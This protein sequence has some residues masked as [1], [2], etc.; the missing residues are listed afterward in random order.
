MRNT[1]GD[2]VS[3]LWLPPLGSLRPGCRLALDARDG[4]ERISFRIFLPAPILG[5][6]DS[7]LFAFSLMSE[8]I[9]L[10]H[11]AEVASYYVACDLGAETG[12]VMLGKLA[13]GKIQIEEVHRF[14][15][16]PVSFMGS[17]R[18]DLLFLFRELKTG[19]CK[20]AARGV[21]VKSLSVDSWGVDYV[22]SGASQPMLSPPYMYRDPRTEPHYARALRE[23]G[24]ELIYAE[25]GVQFMVINTLCQLMADMRLSPDLLRLS[26]GFLCVADFFNFLFSGVR[27]AEVSLASTTQLYNPTQK[28]WSKILCDL[29]GL[30]TRVLPELVTA[31]TILGP[32]LPEVVAETGLKELQVVATCS[33]DT[34]A[35][36]AAVPGSELP[37]WAYLSSGTWSLIGVEL[38]APLVTSEA[39][40]AGFTNEVG[41]GDSIRFLR[42]IVGLWILQECRREWDRQGQVFDY[43]DL[44]NMASEA[45]PLRTLINP[46]DPRFVKP[47]EMPA[48]IEAFCRETGQPLPE[49]PGQFVRAILESL[50]LLYRDTLNTLEKLT[51]RTIRN[52]HIV[53]GGCKN[54]LLNQFA[55]DATGRVVLAGPTECTAAGNILIQAMAH[56]EIASL[57]K[58][59]ETVQ[60]SFPIR[61]FHP[62]LNGDWKV[63]YERFL[64]IRS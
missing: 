2:P 50:A 6:V 10:Q 63:A 27:R 18:W 7:S 49:V 9:L 3:C 29:I 17:M 61:Q 12:R 60:A 45:E 52:L 64:Q 40:Q 62:R 21:P 41:V 32:L 51:T 44:T 1:L 14:H 30:P 4:S 20:V 58:L 31:G 24:K 37:D 33:H 11:D 19:L 16:S 38:R 56:G 26:D 53:G 39:C 36:M 13:G 5:D 8:R 34:G 15:N 42:N 47:G 35:A 54:D 48:K 46:D 28:A 23:I 55:A 25:T 43:T 57:S 22:W 59:R